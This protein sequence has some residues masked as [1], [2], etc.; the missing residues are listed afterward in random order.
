[1]MEFYK[2]NKINPFA[3]C[4]PVP[5]P[6]PVLHRALPA[7][8]QRRVHGRRASPA[9]RRRLPVRRLDLI[10]KPTGAEADRPDHPLL[11]HD[12]RPRLYDHGPPRRE[13]AQRIIFRAARHLRAVHRQLPGGPG[14]LLDRDEHLD[15]GP[16]DGREEAHPGAAK[17]TTEEE[18]RRRRPAPAPAAQEE[19]A[20][21]APGAQDA[22]RRRTRR[23]PSPAAAQPACNV[24]SRRWR[25]PAQHCI[26]AEPAERVEPIL[27]RDRRRRRPRAPT[28][29]SSETDEE[30]TGPLDGRGPRRSSSAAAA[31][32]STRCS[33]SAT[34]PRSAAATS[35]SASRSTPP[36]TASERRESVE[37]QADRA[38]ER[39]LESGKEIELE[40][41]SPTERRI[42]HQHLKD[43]SGI[44]TFSEGTEPERCV[45]SLRWSP[46]DGAEPATRLGRDAGRRRGARASCS[47]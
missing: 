17:P 24:D 43:R 10:E 4:L 42:V 6:A 18:A 9:A 46:I 28:S 21:V 34:A 32:R 47:T 12:G 44:E 1:M 20:A 45:S 41:M 11:R 40:P 23:D 8:A 14:R 25:A 37:R 31:R 7:A 39:A 38:A 36:A 15:D 35:A 27:E 33:S 19:E 13:G 30:I 3:S 22:S 26:P 2:E 5:P 29:R 16:A